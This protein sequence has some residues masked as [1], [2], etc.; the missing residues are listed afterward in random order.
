MRSLTD[1]ERVLKGVLPYAECYA[2]VVRAIG[3]LVSL[4]AHEIRIVRLVAC[5]L[6]DKEIAKR[7]NLTAKTVTACV[8]VVLHRLRLKHRTQLALW[9][10]RVGLVQLE[11]AWAQV[12]FFQLADHR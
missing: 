8:S 2:E 4:R 1:Q 9:A 11:D 7:L 6:P 10:L 12:V 5:G 3:I